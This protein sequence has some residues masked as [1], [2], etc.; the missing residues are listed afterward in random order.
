MRRQAR[1][2]VVAVAAALPLAGGV[3]VAA[4]A[5]AQA[6]VVLSVGHV[7][8]IEVHLE[9]GELALAVRDDTVDPS[10]S[11]D[12]ADVMFQALAGAAVEVPDIPAY[13]A[14][15]GPAGTTVWILPQIQ[16]PGLLWPGWN[17][18]ALSQGVFA[19]DEVSLRLLDVAGAGRVTLFTVDAVGEPTVLFRSDD[20]LPDAVGVPVRSHS[21]ANWTFGAAGSYT[22]TFQVDA[23]LTGGTPVSS[24]PVP[25][26][27]VVGELAE[28][29]ELAVAG[30]QPS[31]PVG[32]TVSLEAVADPEPGQASY[33]WL[34]RCPGEPEF[35][36]VVGETG[37]GY[38]FT[39]TAG[40]DGCQ[41]RVQLH[42]GGS[43]VAESP[44]VTLAVEPAAGPNLSQLIVATID[45]AEGALVV[46]VDP[47][48]RTV[49]LPVAEL[50][51]GGD[52][53][54]TT[55]QL[56]PVRVTDT[57]SAQP[58]WN[59]S[60]QVSDFTGGDAGGFDGKFLGWTP[61]VATQAEGQQV[62]AGPAVPSGFDSGSGLAASSVLGSAPAGAGRGTAELTAGL[63]LELPTET[64]PGTYTAILTL[65]AI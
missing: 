12:P 6:E 52:R 29:P 65:T 36:A 16:D 41:Y 62:I 30:M 24:G 40:L 49:Q 26:R 22:L 27:F 31:Y 48:D 45:E 18:L 9:D 61:A 58:G 42:E 3:V 17:T 32:A 63:R 59:V 39:A 43:L 28:P 21:H 13:T 46:S 8:V 10:V 11:R 23:T 44:P 7:D 56:R 57:R 14:F 60:G 4:P 34:R 38:E 15:L 37:A 19:G 1:A 50:S 35:A 5:A 55:G 33:Q 20:G 47:A 25:Y 51:T 54:Q 53:W 2:L 64:P